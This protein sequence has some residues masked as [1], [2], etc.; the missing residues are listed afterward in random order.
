MAACLHGLALR[1]LMSSGLLK[2][3]PPLAHAHKLLLQP[4]VRQSQQAYHHNKS[5]R[6]NRNS[7]IKNFLSTEQKSL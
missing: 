5:L 3:L 2:Q 1:P 4:V 6:Y 7:C